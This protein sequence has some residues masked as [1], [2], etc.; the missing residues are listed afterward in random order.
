MSKLNTSFLIIFLLLAATL[1]FPFAARADIYKYVDKNG[2]THFVDDLGKVPPEYR[3]QVTVREEKPVGP[4]PEGEAPQAVE[5][6]GETPEEERTRRMLE[7]LE[8]KK[9]QDEDKARE[10]FEKSRVTKVTIRGNQ[11]LVP[12]TLGYGGKE[13]QASLVLDT[14]AEM[15]VIHQATADRLNLLLTK[16]AGVRVG[17]GGVI[18]ARVATLDYVRVGPYEAKEVHVWV[19]FPQGPQTGE[20]GAL[21]MNFLRGLEYSIDFEN[22]VI[23]WKAQ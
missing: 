11:V 23:R 17:G 6:K 18:N 8:E 19:V 20:D 12:V 2:T 3:D 7:G 4:P 14:G 10:E 16:R 15:I 1:F 22:Q 5:K 21:G 13:V 9:R